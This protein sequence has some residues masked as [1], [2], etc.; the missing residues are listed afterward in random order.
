MIKCNKHKTNIH[1]SI[2]TVSEDFTNIVINVKQF[3]SERM[4]ED[5]A[6][7]CLVTCVKLAYAA[8]DEEKRA[9]LEKEL[10]ERF[11]EGFQRR[12]ELMTS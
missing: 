3:F 4:P 8:D 2:L 7:R 12:H 9:K 11:E 1:G 10:M 6:S 5:V